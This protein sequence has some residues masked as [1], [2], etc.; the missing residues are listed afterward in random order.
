MYSV[1]ILVCECILFFVFWR[2]CK[3]GHDRL[4]DYRPN[5]W[6][7]VS[8]KSNSN[9]IWVRVSFYSCTFSHI[10]PN[11][12]LR[13]EKLT[14]F[15]VMQIIVR[16]INSPQRIFLLTTSYIAFYIPIQ[17]SIL[18]N[19]SLLCNIASHFNT[20]SVFRKPV[21]WKTEEGLHGLHYTQCWDSSWF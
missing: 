18:T 9:K 14:N 5:M 6:C 10:W 20:A 16:A 3:W 7:H 4:Y 17:A 11:L 19:G 21:E 2:G 1:C 12:C 15:P 13:A 8:I